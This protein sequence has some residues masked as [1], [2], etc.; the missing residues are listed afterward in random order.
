MN[1]YKDNSGQKEAAERKLQPIKALLLRLVS[2][3]FVVVPESPEN[4]EKH[5][6]RHRKVLIF[7][8]Y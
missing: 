7:A 6:L 8:Q 2:K 1:I 5:A 4:G 3:M